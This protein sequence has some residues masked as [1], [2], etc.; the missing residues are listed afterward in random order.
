MSN[1][2]NIDDIDWA[3]LTCLSPILE[4]SDPPNDF[5]DDTAIDHA[6]ATMVQ[7]SVQELSSMML[8]QDPF[9]SPALEIDFDA[10]MMPMELSDME[11]STRLDDPHPP[12]NVTFGV[13]QRLHG[14][15]LS[16]ST[17]RLPEADT[18]LSLLDMID[19]DKDL[20]PPICG[21]MAD[22]TFMSAGIPD[23]I[24]SPLVAP[25]RKVVKSAYV[26][27]LPKPQCVNHQ[28]SSTEAI[29]GPT[30]EKVVPRKRAL[31]NDLVGH[32]T[33]QQAPTGV[34]DGFCFS[35]KLPD[36]RDP[37]KGRTRAKKTCLRCHE[38]KIKVRVTL[39]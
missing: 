28:H 19:F 36:T 35:F 31:S 24:T 11:M 20:D 13:P 30:L 12:Q 34:P 16:Q 25:S 5:A 3:A 33:L 17:V 37:K 4:P 29:S 10:T 6:H 23:A 7:G 39:G 14:D 2:N 32:T 22:Q 21:A 18:E 8:D 9:E 1:V 38:Q 15:A 26:N 27:L